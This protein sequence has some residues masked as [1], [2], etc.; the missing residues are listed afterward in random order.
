MPINS[1]EE[2]IHLLQKKGKTTS[3]SIRE[4]LKIL[5]EKGSFLT[6]IFLSLPFCQPLM[7]PG[8][9]LPF[10]LA[11]FAIGIQMILGKNLWL[12]KF[13][14]QK[15]IEPASLEKLTSTLTWTLKKIK[16]FSH[17]RISF[18]TQNTSV[19]KIHHLSIAFLGF[20]LAI[21]LPIPFSNLT[22][23][24]SL[25]LISF[26]VLEDDGLFVLIGYISFLIT[27]LFFS[28][29]FLSIKHFV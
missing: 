22:T 29:I 28:A 13:I 2:K 10:G 9:S 21:P 18:L 11:I 16:Y 8:L 4:I 17:P 14:H 23:A 6:L 3:L 5:S 12:P 27:I 20:L 26:G 19:Q 24:W 7:I 15:H 25:F 1:L